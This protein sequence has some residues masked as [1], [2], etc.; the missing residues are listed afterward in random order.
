MGTSI[1]PDISKKNPYWIDR[2]RYY[3]LKHF[4]LQ[5]PSYKKFYFSL[6]GYSPKSA[7]QSSG[8]ERQVDPTSMTA[9]KRL[10]YLNRINMIETAAKEA[11]VVI[12]DYI[13]I[14]VTKGLS[15]EH[16]RARYSVPCC[17]DVYYNVYR[18]FFWLLS[19]ARQ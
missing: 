1:R 18:R 13:L 7:L 10:S 4:C 8:I 3:E 5:Y 12:G 6:D 19:E 9:A 16:M 2:H 17:K 11:D 14:A 15:Y